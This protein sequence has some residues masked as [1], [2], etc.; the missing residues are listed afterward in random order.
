[1]TSR[2]PELAIID[3]SV[4]VDNVRSGRF[5]GNLLALPYLVRV[6]A[7]VVAELARGA[8][9]RQAKQFIAYMIKNFS[10]LAPTEAEWIRSGHVVR[11]LTDRHRLDIHKLR[12]IHFD[13]LIALTARRLGAHLI[14]SN[15]RDYL[16]IQKVLSFKLICW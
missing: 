12:E 6:S 15:A 1:M 13:V 7:V 4:Y 9:S 3:T 10:P 8:R 16:A 2:P 14:T 5:E 11:A